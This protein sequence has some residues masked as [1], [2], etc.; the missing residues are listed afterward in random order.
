MQLLN[1]SNG[2][3]K[4]A[5]LVISMG[6]P[7][8]IGP[9][10]V[11]AAWR[12]MRAKAS[13]AF[14]YI[15]DPATI[16]GAPLECVT[17]IA[18]APEIFADA[19]P[20]LDQPL[21]HAAVSGQPSAANAPAVIAALETAAKLCSEGKASGMVTAPVAK[22]QLYE[23]GFEAPGQT[24]FLADLCKTARLE[25]VMMLA[26]PS[27]RVVPVT[28]HTALADVPRHV[29]KELIVARAATTH[30][31]LRA[32]FDIKKPRLA[33]CG[34]NPHAG[35]HGAIGREEIETIEPAI[36]MLRA[37]GIDIT[38]PY[39]ADSLFHAEARGRYDAVLAMYH[40]Q[41]LVPFKT[42][43]FYDGVNV[44]LGLPIVRTSPDHGTA[45][46]IAGQGKADAQS[47]LAA[48][49]LAASIAERRAMQN[50]DG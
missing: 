40:D 36:A 14:A 47:M 8:G 42:L 24:E 20:I 2:P 31:A 41:G 44:T 12:E 5:P 30:A 15:A 17:D 23:A 25:T 26:G 48:I 10:I 21:A 29:T 4:S 46:D 19:L 43:H 34:L 1:T 9:E 33:V 18:Q 27:L 13:R 7:A 32:D 28:I 3:G 45:F 6:D 11:S 22:Q 35:E 50:H 16:T 49:N 37:R 38:G 39:P